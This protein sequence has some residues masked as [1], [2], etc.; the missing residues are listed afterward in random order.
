MWTFSYPSAGQ[1]IEVVVQN[2]RV[3]AVYT[4]AE[5]PRDPYLIAPGTIEDGVHYGYLSDA[6]GMTQLTFDRVD[7]A[8]DGS[9]SNTN[10]NLRTLPTDPQVWTFSYPSAGQPI[11]VVV[12]N[13]RVTAVYA[14]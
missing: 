3:T 9:W 1:P 7:V 12:Q 10:S 2:Q 8:A 11:E 6:S 5:P 14:V 13:Q 4:A